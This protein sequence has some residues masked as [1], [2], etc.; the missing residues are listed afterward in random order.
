MSCR[1]DIVVY[2]AT[3]FTG[4][5]IVRALAT[6]PLFKYILYGEAVV[7]AAVENGA[8][9]VDISGE[10]VF[11]ERMVH[12]YSE[13]AKEKGVYILGACGF[14]SI[15][16]DMGVEFLK[17]NFDGTLGCVETFARFNKGVAGYPVNTGTYDSMLLAIASL[18]D[19]GARQVHRE[20]TPNPMPQ[21]KYG[22][23]CRFPLTR[24]K[25]GAQNA[26]N[27]PFVGPDKSIVDRSQYYDFH[28]NN[29]RA[30][31]IKTYMCRGS[32]IQTALSTLWLSIFAFFALFS[33]TRKFLK[34]HPECCSFGMF[35]R[36]G[37]SKQQIGEA[38]F[39]YF[40]YGAGWAR[41]ETPDAT[42]PTKT[43]VA[44]CHGPDPGYVG[45]AACITAAAL[46]LLDDK[47]KL[48]KE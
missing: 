22:A 15:P 9:H 7:K 38:S 35:R 32:F 39:D 19:R 45:T 30:V 41:D 31:Q 21:P 27:V 18:W 36:N 10:P 28:V 11:L 44:V 17:R 47:D 37:P 42:R 1:Y 6:S 26:W 14:D 46:T 5:Y 12:K 33:P 29:K 16:C 24:Q 20:I 2:G 43:A 4:A 40:F 8:N 25:L 13:A 3:G 23:P 48:P 34:A